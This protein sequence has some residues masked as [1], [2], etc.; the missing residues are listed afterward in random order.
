[1]VIIVFQVQFQMFYENKLIESSPQT[2]G[3][4]TIFVSILQLGKL[5]H[6]EIIL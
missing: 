4:R 5:R 6:R 3:V 2:Y 1:M